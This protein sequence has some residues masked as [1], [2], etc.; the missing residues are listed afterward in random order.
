MIEITK[1]KG[2]PIL[3]IKDEDGRYPF[4]MSVE[5]AKLILQHIED[6]KRFVGDCNEN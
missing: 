6:I 2:H 3:V 1:Y 5:K 4:S